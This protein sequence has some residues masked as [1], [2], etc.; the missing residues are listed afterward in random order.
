MHPQLIAFELAGRPLVIGSYGVLLSVALALAAL[1]L[2]RAARAL[3][4]ELGVAITAAGTAVGA[5]LAGALAFHGVLAFAEHGTLQP[6]SLSMFGALLGAGAG[7]WLAARAL[8]FGA[9]ELMRRALPSVALA[10]AV[11]RVG[12][13]LGGC[14]HGQPWHVQGSV[15]VAAAQ[16]ELIV[17]RH[18][19]PLYEAL[20]LLGLAS[21]FAL[22]KRV[23]QSTPERAV[24][25]YLALYAGMRLLLDTLRDPAAGGPD[26]AHA[27]ALGSSQAAAVA[28]L[29]AAA[30]AFAGL[31]LRA[32]FWQ[33]ASAR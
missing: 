30:L 15:T 1:G 33:R 12:C 31:A 11:A 27:H 4:I 29:A 7:V 24:L 5:G 21:W 32:R 28:V 22:R 3:R 6:A 26:Y 10:Q 17:E 23:A 16:L 14:C 9:F 8:G 19:L 20:L 25:L 13:W 18:P 2:L